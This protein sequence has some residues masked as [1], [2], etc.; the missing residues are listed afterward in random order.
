MCKLLFGNKD[1]GFGKLIILHAKKQP[2][3]DADVA[4]RL[5]SSRHYD[6]FLDTAVLAERDDNIT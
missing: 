6:T 1:T 3:T 4:A 2:G 5:L